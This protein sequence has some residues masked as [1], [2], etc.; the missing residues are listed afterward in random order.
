MKRCPQCEFVYEDD[1]TVCDMDG[2]ELFRDALSLPLP[3][4]ENILPEA[5][6]LPAGSQGSKWR[7]L[8]VP[9]IAGVV[10]AAVLF[11]VYYAVTHR[12]RPGQSNQ[13]TL[14]ATSVPQPA[15][16]LAPSPSLAEAP[17]PEQS[18]NLTESSPPVQPATAARLTSSPVSAAGGTGRGPVVIRLNN[19][20]AI[21]ADE[22]WEKRE[23][24]WYRQ[25]GM[26][27]FLKRSRVRAIESSARPRSV[28]PK[29]D[30]KKPKPESAKPKKESTI[31]SILKTT[32]R[33]LKKPFKL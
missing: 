25:A 20:A 3:A 29:P 1:Q 24:I 6:K 22:A 7:G 5:G 16:D 32:G 11:L 8:A 21:M 15:P 27:T 17:S 23:G 31:G 28:P 18:P 2:S 12:S 26:V 14:S 10:L 13:S 30:A 9:A 4:L 33:I 19:G